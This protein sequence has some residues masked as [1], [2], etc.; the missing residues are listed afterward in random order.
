MSDDRPGSTPPAPGGRQPHLW[1]GRGGFESFRAYVLEAQVDERR[2][3]KAED[4]PIA[5]VSLTVGKS[6]R[7]IFP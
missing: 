2:S 4:A 6:W 1:G 5:V 3:P 7:E